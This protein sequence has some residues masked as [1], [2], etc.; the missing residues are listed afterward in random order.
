MFLFSNS[1]KQTKMFIPVNNL[2][3]QIMSPLK[4]VYNAK[5]LLREY[6]SAS[7]KTLCLLF[8]P[9]QGYNTQNCFEKQKTVVF[10]WDTE[11]NGLA[12]SG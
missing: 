3:T 5:I 7:K 10:L 9:K 2:Y 12:I 8:T 11:W 1:E 4:N 6:F